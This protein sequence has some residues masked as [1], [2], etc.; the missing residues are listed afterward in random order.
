MSDQSTVVQVYVLWAYMSD[1][2]SAKL[3]GVYGDMVT[4]NE[5]L[6]AQA[7]AG[8]VY[9]LQVRKMTLNQIDVQDIFP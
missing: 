1:R 7:A 3:F 6:K 9:Q 8:S 5:I 4:I 2:S